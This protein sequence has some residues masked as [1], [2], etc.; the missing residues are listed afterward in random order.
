MAFDAHKEQVDKTGMP[1]IFHPFH[2]AEQMDDE[3]T[4]CIALLH[5]VVEDTE[6][7]LNDLRVQGFSNRII[8]ALSLLTHGDDVE[9]LEYVEKIKSNS[10]AT[11][12]KLADLQHNSDTTRLDIMDDNVKQ[13]IEKY[14]KA[15]A[16][17]SSRKKPQR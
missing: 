1:Y 6:I 2:L 4:V 11:K 15:I 3:E 10:L 8:D 13:R 16:L 14:A 9:Y 7:T 12:V 17:L 5:D